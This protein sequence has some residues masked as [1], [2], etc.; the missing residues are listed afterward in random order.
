MAERILIL[1]TTGVS[2]STAIANLRKYR[3]S[4]HGC[5]N[6]EHFNLEDFI[7]EKNRISVFRYLDTEY[8]QQI[9]YWLKGWDGLITKLNEC[10]DQN[11][12]LSMHSVLARRWYGTRSPVRLERVVKDFNPTIIITLINDVYLQWHTTHEHAG[13]ENHIGKPSL[14]QLLQARRSEIFFGDLIARQVTAN[15]PPPYPPHYVISVWHPARVLDRVLF[16]ESLKTVYLSFPISKPRK[17]KLAGDDTGVR[18]MNSVLSTVSEL[19]LRAHDIA[20]FCPLTIDEYP[21]LMA[22][23]KELSVGCDESEILTVFETKTRWNT[24]DFYGEETLLITD[25]LPE[26]IKIPEEQINHAE[27]MIKADVGIRDYRLVEQSESL[28]VLNPVF[29]T[30]DG[31]FKFARGVYDEIRFAIKKEIPIY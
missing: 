27:G 19:D 15:D 11:V 7:I 6:F 22:E 26:E 2:K 12:L 14:E 3:E 13:R 21:L 20:T 24:R 18:E 10:K 1:G 8:D 30:T 16:R 23:S 17:L 25:D 29:K 9:Q 28:A 4:L 31:D 5:A